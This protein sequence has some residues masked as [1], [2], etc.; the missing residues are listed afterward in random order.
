M[1]QTKCI[2]ARIGN[3]DGYRISVMSRH[4]LNDGITP[5][6]TINE[7][8]YDAWWPQL[9]PPALLI[10]SYYKRGLLW[11]EFA[12]E[13]NRYLQTEKAEAVINNLAHLALAS[14]VTILCTESSP[15]LCHRSLI[16]NRCSSLYP[17]LAVEMS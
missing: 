15:E 16:A 1:L 6:P 5:D 12:E 10:G 9:A 8:M 7:T 14:N 13:Y 4:T 11:T 3:N 17:S 2:R